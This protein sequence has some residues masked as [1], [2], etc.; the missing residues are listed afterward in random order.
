[1]KFLDR[2]FI[3]VVALIVVALSM[4]IFGFYFDLFSQY[5]IAN[6]ITDLEGK[7]EALAAAVVLF[8][9]AA[10]IIQLSLMSKKDKQ[11]IIGEG[12]LGTVRVTI[13]A[14]NR[15]VKDIASQ[16]TNAKDIKSKI[17]TTDSG[18]NIVLDLAVYNK[19]KV[20]NL[21][22]ELQHHVKAAIEEAIG[23]KVNR[24]EVLVR[25]IEKKDEGKR[26]LQLD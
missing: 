25:A 15:F 11:T 4:G 21:A 17:K 9:I 14:I 19:V 6:F 16:E 2:F 5:K 1:M 3:F 18:L 12:E 7:I 10:R 8:L 20:P 22:D 13:E 26:K 23:A 24:V